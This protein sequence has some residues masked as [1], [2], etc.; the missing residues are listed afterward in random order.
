[1]CLMIQFNELHT[2]IDME[3]YKNGLRDI[4]YCVFKLTSILFIRLNLNPFIKV[5]FSIFSDLS[6]L[7]QS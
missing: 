6:Q 3:Y 5:T 2:Y 1:M 4:I 7:S